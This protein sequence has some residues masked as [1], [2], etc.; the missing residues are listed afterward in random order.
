M[1]KIIVILTLVIAVLLTLLCICRLSKSDKKLVEPVANY[2]FEY[3]IKCDLDSITSRHG[4]VP[5]FYEAQGKF[6]KNLTSEDSLHVVW[7]LTAWSVNNKTVVITHTEKNGTIVEVSDAPW[8]G[9]RP[10]TKVG[11]NLKEALDRL[12]AADLPKPESNLFVLR[13]PLIKHDPGCPIY[14]FGSVMTSF[15]SVNSETGEVKQIEE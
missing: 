13:H 7:I 3:I 1:K 12:R 4:E 10:M 6:D 11:L 8:G 2:D 5:I 9:D 14:V 15:V